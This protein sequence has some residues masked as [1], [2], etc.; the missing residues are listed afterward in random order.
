MDMNELNKTGDLAETDD[1]IKIAEFELQLWRVFYGFLR[2]QAGCERS[3]NGTELTG[4]ELAVL[5]I[6]RL[7]DRPKSISDISRLLNRDDT[8]NIQYCI[9]KILKMGLIEKIKSPSQKT[10]VFQVTEKGIK[11]TNTY[12]QARKSIL[13][14]GFIKESNLPLEDITKSLAQLKAIYDEADRTAASYKPSTENKSD[15]KLQKR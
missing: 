4:N 6:I 11:N 12:V 2:W 14:E 10:F 1:E 9:R 13:I 15:N 8:F 5:H 7:K 3:A